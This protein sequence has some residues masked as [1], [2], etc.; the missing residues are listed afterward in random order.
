MMSRREARSELKRLNRDLAAVDADQTGTGPDET[1]PW[2]RRLLW[3]RP[4]GRQRR[5][6][7]STVLARQLK[8]TCGIDWAEKHHD[9]ALVD[10]DGKLVA[11]R[12]DDVAGWQALVALRHVPPGEYEALY[13]RHNHG[14]ADHSHNLEP[15]P[16]PG[17]FTVP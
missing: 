16:N 17:C 8:V 3:T 15:L 2:W 13:Y 4:Q 9:V 14:I 6:L 1:S 7:D 10:S 5:A 11:R 12:R